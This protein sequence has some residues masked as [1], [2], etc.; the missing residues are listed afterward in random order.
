MKKKEIMAM[1]AIG[2][3]MVACSDNELHEHGNDWEGN[4][5]LELSASISETVLSKADGNFTAGEYYFSYVSN[6]QTS[7]RYTDTKTDFDVSGT[8]KS[9]LTWDKINTNSSLKNK[10]FILDN[11]PYQITNETTTSFT[12]SDGKIKLSEIKESS[13]DITGSTSETTDEV[14]EEESEKSK[15][16][17]APAPEISGK[18]NDLLWATVKVDDQIP[19]SPVHFELEHKMAMLTFDLYSKNDEIKELLKQN[20]TVKLEGV[21]TEPTTFNRVTGVVSVDYPSNGE[22][23]SYIDDMGVLE[24]T[25]DEEKGVARCTKSWIFPPQQFHNIGRPVLNVTLSKTEAEG[26]ETITKTFRGRLP[27]SMIYNKKSELLEFISGCH[28]II[29]VELGDVNNM[30]IRF[31]PVL[32][33]KW[34]PKTIV[35]INVD[36]VGVRTANELLDL[37][38]TYNGNPNNPILWRYGV[39]KNNDEDKP[40]W[41]FDLWS[42]ISGY[43]KPSN[44]STSNDLGFNTDQTPGFI[45]NSHN[46]K[47]NDK[48]VDKYGN[49]E[50]EDTTTP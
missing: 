15:Y 13:E 22:V 19:L 30:E 1:A 12:S 6:T 29:E 32:V 33:R 3:V 18:G 17:A 25:E 8:G 14:E 21:I 44:S 11:V 41:Y 34:I 50:D 37:V 43:T 36:Q 46:Y 39:L 9:Y 38:K 48:T 31:R 2:I 35:D 45:I 24:P 7:L 42:N 28:L 16:T 47:V 20:V 5:P 27:E 10:L 23:S 40:T 49:L 4:E 26:T